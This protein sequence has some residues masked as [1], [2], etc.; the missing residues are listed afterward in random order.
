[1]I[2]D[3]GFA[4]LFSGVS[5]QTLP[6]GRPNTFSMFAWILFT[7]ASLLADLNLEPEYFLVGPESGS[8]SSRPSHISRFHLNGFLHRVLP[9]L[10]T[11]S[12]FTL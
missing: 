8:A 9:G 5:K 3:F 4:F 1:L 11:R 2:E 10:L 12:I 6:P 7:D